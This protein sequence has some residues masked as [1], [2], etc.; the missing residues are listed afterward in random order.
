VQQRFQAEKRAKAEHAYQAVVA[1]EEEFALRRLALDVKVFQQESISERAKGRLDGKRGA[2]R[3]ALQMLN[4]RL[5]RENP[6][7][8]PDAEDAWAWNLDNY[9]SEDLEDLELEAEI[10]AF[11]DLEEY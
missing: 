1:Q 11:S 10:A 5:Q 8:D 4:K 3:H 2:E 7:A 6:D 9:T